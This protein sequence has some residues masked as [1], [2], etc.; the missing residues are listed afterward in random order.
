[1]VVRSIEKADPP[2]L[3]ELHG[4]LNP[5]DRALA[6]EDLVSVWKQLSRYPG[7]TIFAGERTES[8]CHISRMGLSGHIPCFVFTMDSEL[9]VVERIRA[10]GVV[11]EAEA[12]VRPFRD[13]YDPSAAAGVPAHI[14]LLYPFKAPDEVGDI[15]LDKLRD[16]FA[17]L[18]PIQFSLGKIQRFPV[19]VLHLAPEPDDPFRQLTLSIWN[20][21]PETPP[22]GGK[23]PDIIPHLSLAQLANEQQL[24]AIAGD[25]AKA[26]QG[27]LPIHAIAS[28][29]AL[30]EN[31][32]GRRRVRAMFGLGLRAVEHCCQN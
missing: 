20:L 31:R 22:Y 18:E 27:K 7:S 9:H 15:V 16:C 4:D 23:W 25:F 24:T 12:V 30:M 11:P 21:F 13:Q 2:V 19:G 17:C 8:S 3:L 1:L 32:S 26:S 28:E 10:G 5:S 29:V 14:T 6:L